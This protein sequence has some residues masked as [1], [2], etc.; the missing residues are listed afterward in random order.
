MSDFDFGDA[1][2]DTIENR[3]NTVGFI[4]AQGAANQRAAQLKSLEDQ[5]AVDKSRATT[6]KERLSVEM[7]RLEIE[8]ERLALERDAKSSGEALAKEIRVLRGI[9]LDI[10][11]DLAGIR[12]GASTMLSGRLDQAITLRVAYVQVLLKLIGD[13]SH[14]LCDL[15]DLKEFRRLGSEFTGVSR[16]CY[17]K[18][19]SPGD[20][21]QLVV[22]EIKNLDKWGASAKTLLD[23]G[24]RM[25]SSDFLREGSFRAGLL[26]MAAVRAEL[27]V[28]IQTV[29]GDVER[30]SRQ[31][32]LF[33]FKGQS[34]NSSVGVIWEL[35]YENRPSAEWFNPL[36]QSRKEL[37]QTKE[38]VEK[39]SAQL[40]QIGWLEAHA[41]VDNDTLRQ[42]LQE[43]EGG[44][45]QNARMLSARPVS[46][47]FNDP[48]WEKLA[49]RL[50][51]MDTEYAAAYA[52]VIKGW[53]PLEMGRTI[54]SLRQ[55]MLWA[56]VKP[57]SEWGVK[58]NAFE[59]KARRYNARFHEASVVI[60]F[61]L[62][63]LPALLTS[64]VY[65]SNQE[66]SAAMKKAE[67]ELESDAK[68]GAGEVKVI[69]IAPG[70]TMD[71]CWCPAGKFTMGS[72]ESEA[73]RS[74]DEDQVQVTL[75]EGFWMAKTEVTQAQWQAVMKENPSEFKG[76]NRP[77]EKVS[78][79]DAQKFLTK[80]NAIVGDSDGRKM[81]LPTEAQW[82]YAARAGETGPY[83]GGTVKEVAWYRDNSGGGTH[84]VG[85]KRPNAWG[86]HDMHG[87]VWEWCADWYKDEL[88]GGVDPQGAASGSGRVFRGGSWN[89]FAFFCRVS[90]R[91]WYF[92]S[93]WGYGIGFRPA[94]G[95]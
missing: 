35:L 2:E 86:L 53:D 60:I 13:R 62:V 17:Q 45:P 85:T 67:I 92:P 11:D 59:L 50:Q 19:L 64:L 48:Q 8:E 57:H 23:S 10:G 31:L 46:E 83:S 71:F 41:R 63:F 18:G 84:E 38:W 5:L 91:Y 44:N 87:N 30:I 74:S 52:V 36:R 43:L 61:L 47:R 75:S 21:L 55:N 79:D 65:Q 26:R 14:V 24:R 90:F 40:S 29:D 1:L 95:Q 72:P 93:N 7:R 77:V 81:V 6:E 49:V 94:R 34:L 89:Y 33:C 37:G 20:S 58:L 32:P 54:Q 76:A 42:A 15:G 68:R 9:M 22:D 16:E 88:E 51:K 39:A 25:L 66:L 80:L 69:E 4:F 12:K 82:E 27:E 78:W 3:Q 73:G 28:F 56:N 70:V